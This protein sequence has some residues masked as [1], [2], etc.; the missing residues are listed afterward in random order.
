[1]VVLDQNDFCV[2]KLFI[3]ETSKPWVDIVIWSNLTREYVAN[4]NWWP[5]LEIWAAT[6]VIVLTFVFFFCDFCT[7][8]IPWDSSPILNSPP[9]WGVT[10]YVKCFSNHQT[11]AN[12]SSTSGVRCT[13]GATWGEP[14]VA[15]DVTLTVRTSKDVNRRAARKWLEIST[16][17]VRGGCRDTVAPWFFEQH[18]EF[19]PYFGWKF[20][21]LTYMFCR[22]VV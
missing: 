10:N 17:H 11:F 18:L 15:N 22:W 3:C 7:A 20:P 13:D 8:S 9:I 19:H 6:A 4:L 2:C 12:P 5:K 21:R 1:M 14:F 16:F